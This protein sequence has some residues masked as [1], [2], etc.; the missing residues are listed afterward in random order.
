MFITGGFHSRQCH[1]MKKSGEN[2][3]KVIMALSMAV[4]STVAAAQGQDAV[5]KTEVRGSERAL[6]DY[7][8]ESKQFNDTDL[9]ACAILVNG[10]PA[11]TQANGTSCK[12]GG[13]NIHICKFSNGQ[14]CYF[15]FNSLD[16]E[17]TCLTF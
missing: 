10:I 8:A 13:A 9:S 3:M 15:D 16:I 4:A 11:E 2:S 1:C 12:S 14:T 7:C 17:V 5:V 6:L